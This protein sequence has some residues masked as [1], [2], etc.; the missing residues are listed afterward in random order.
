MTEPT[1][2]TPSPAP[3]PKERT[4]GVRVPLPPD[5]RPSEAASPGR[6][7]RRAAALQPRRRFGGTEAQ[8]RGA[9]SFYMVCAW[10]SGTFLL[11]L[12]A[13][14]ITR[15]G[16]GYDLIA[17]GTD[18]ATGQTVALGWQDLELENLAGGV[19]ISTWILIVHGWFYVVY[20]ISCFRIWTLMRWPFPQ[21]VVMALGGVVP[22]LS[23]VVERKIHASTTAELRA[24]PKAAKR[25]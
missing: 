7:P 12:V 11:L 14:M 16:L 25:Y 2:P 8:I 6:V 22:F 21:L 3:V 19:N 23:F 18:R 1:Q 10:I 4:D 15:Y 24:H 9:L 13:E 5:A 20:L 17:G